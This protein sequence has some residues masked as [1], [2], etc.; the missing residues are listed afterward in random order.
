MAHFFV[1]LTAP[2]G[3]RVG[4]FECEIFPASYPIFD[5]RDY[6]GG[7][8]ATGFGLVVTEQP[9]SVKSPL[10][11]HERRER[12]DHTLLS[13]RSLSRSD[14]PNTS[15]CSTKQPDRLVP[16]SVQHILLR[17]ISAPHSC[18]NAQKRLHIFLLSLP[19]QHTTAVGCGDYCCGFGRKKH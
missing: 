14:G 15:S 7:G 8:T 6:I 1:P 3:C 11:S 17:E 18:S 13:R 12:A 2:H 19:Q 10:N 9:F 16:F 4:S 5:I